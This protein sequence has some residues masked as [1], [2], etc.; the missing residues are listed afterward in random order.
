MV[1]LENGASEVS[2]AAG[3]SLNTHL[4]AALAAALT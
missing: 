2:E 4:M 1:G 3:M